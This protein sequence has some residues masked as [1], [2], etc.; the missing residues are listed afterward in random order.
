MWQYILIRKERDG[1]FFTVSSHIHNGNKIMMEC[2]IESLQW[3]ANSKP[4]VGLGR[5]GHKQ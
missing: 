2:F 1:K 5:G 3:F 4:A